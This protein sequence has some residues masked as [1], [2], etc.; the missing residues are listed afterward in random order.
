ME[1]CTKVCCVRSVL[2]FRAALTILTD[3]LLME[4]ELKKHNF[5]SK[6][7]VNRRTKCCLWEGVD[8]EI[9]ESPIYFVQPNLGE[10]VLWGVALGSVA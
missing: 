10:L 7:K 4:V 5:E 2:K 3:V 8:K 6:Y 9:S 1:C